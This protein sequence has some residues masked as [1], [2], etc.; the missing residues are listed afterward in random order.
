MA[1]WKQSNVSFFFNFILNCLISCFH[2]LFMSPLSATAYY[3]KFAYQNFV[4]KGIIY[5]QNFSRA[6]KKYFANL[7]IFMIVCNPPTKIPREKRCE[8]RVPTELMLTLNAQKNCDKSIYFH[9]EQGNPRSERFCLLHCLWFIKFTRILSLRALLQWLGLSLCLH[10][11]VSVAEK[12]LMM[13]LWLE[14]AWKRRKSLRHSILIVIAI[15]T[16]G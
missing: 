13:L 9:R 14:K 2:S 4:R 12:V 7:S 16:R 8:R 15:V 6:N 10:L 3:R 5:L 11:Y 1:F